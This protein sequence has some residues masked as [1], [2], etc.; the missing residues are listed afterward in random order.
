MSY[1]YNEDLGIEKKDFDESSLFLSEEPIVDAEIRD[2]EDGRNEGKCNNLK[3]KKNFYIASS[4]LCVLG[5][6][7]V[8]SYRNNSLEK[9]Q[10]NET[11]E[12]TTSQVASKTVKEDNSIEVLDEIDL[13]KEVE[14]LQENDSSLNES[15]LNPEEVE[16]EV[17]IVSEG[18]TQDSD[19]KIEAFYNLEDKLLSEKS[20]EKKEP[21]VVSVPMTSDCFANAMRYWNYFEQYGYMYGIDPY[22][23]IAMSSQESRGDHLSVIP[24]GKYYNG[25]GYGI[26]QI[27]K[28]GVVTKRITAYNHITKSYEIM[29]ISSEDDVYDVGMNIKAGAM[30]LSQKAKEQ[31]YNPYVTIQGYNYGTSGIKY[32]LSYYV[33]NGEIDKV[34]EIYA[35]GKGEHLLYYI[36]INNHDWVNTVTPSGLT[37]R[38]WYSSQGWKR[39]GAGRGD[40]QY[41]EHV[42]RYYRGSDKPYISKDTGEK[43]YF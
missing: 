8:I 14:L 39:F 22:L 27:E 12:D 40:K 4:V 41:I 21:Q 34:E 15:N 37:A 16:G 23:L 7:G 6:V 26:M 24:G 35:N 19:I 13:T 31:Q 29:N 1:D 32:A 36:A 9:A 17:D 3:N 10:N 43:V 18:T 25:Y 42:M 2:I 38:E 28:P 11:F 33:A 20:I 30:I 5:G